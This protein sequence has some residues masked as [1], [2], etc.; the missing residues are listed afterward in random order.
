MTQADGADRDPLDRAFDA[1]GLDVLAETEGVVEQE[2]QARHD[3]VH[4]RLRAGADGEAEHAQ[5]CDQG[6]DV[7]VAEDK[8]GFDPMAKPENLECRTQV[9]VGRCVRAGVPGCS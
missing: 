8:I 3:V 4:Q 6:P 5:A 9:I 2:E 7:H 1:G